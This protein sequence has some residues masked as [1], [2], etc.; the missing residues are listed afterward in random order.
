MALQVINVGNTPNDGTGDPIRTAY[1]KCNNNFAELYSRL[2]DTPPTGPGGT[3]GDAAG[4]L[5]FDE[6]YLYVCIA[7]YDGTSDIW[8]RVVFDTTPW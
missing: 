7:D 3:V 6:T 1:T 2:Q 8:K 5:A 4:M